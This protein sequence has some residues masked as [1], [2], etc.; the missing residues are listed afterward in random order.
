MIEEDNTLGKLKNRLVIHKDEIRNCLNMIKLT[1]KKVLGYGASTKG[2]ILLHYCNISKED[3]PFIGDLNPEKHTRLTPGTRIPIKSHDYIKSLRPD[4]L[5][6]FIWHFRKEII[7]LE[8]EYLK[9]GGKLIFP[10]PRLHCDI[11]NYEFYLNSDFD[12]LA[13]S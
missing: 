8:L 5:F 6:V 4:Y 2:N 12:D 9:K 3:I 7:N 13:F 10:L 1:S 11:F